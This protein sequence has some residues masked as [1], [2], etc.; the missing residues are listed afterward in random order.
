MC[1]SLFAALPFNMTL[2]LQSSLAYGFHLSRS[3]SLF[4]SFPK[5]RD[6]ESMNM[7]VGYSLKQ[8]L[9]SKSNIRRGSKFQTR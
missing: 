7:I 3:L 8:N 5:N 4:I 6:I 2:T 1:N 9:C